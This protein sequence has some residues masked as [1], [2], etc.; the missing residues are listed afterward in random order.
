VAPEQTSPP[1]PKAEP[2]PTPVPGLAAHAAK[3]PPGTTSGSGV[4]RPGG[5]AQDPLNLFG[6]TVGGRFAVVRYLGRTSVAYIYRVVHMLMER[7]CF[8][9]VCD[10][11]P[12]APEGIPPALRREA[13]VTATS[14]NAALLRLLDAGVTGNFA[15][16]TQEWSDGPNLRSIIDQTA[17]LS[18]PDLLAI[19]MQLVDALCDLHR[20]GVVLRA[21]DPERILVPPRAG[22]PWLRLFDLSRIAWVGEKAPGES[23]EKSKRAT[24]F[25]IRSTRYMA[26][27]EIREVPADPRS[28]IYSLGV[29]LYEMLTGEYPY[30]TRGQGPGAYVVS[31][32]RDA[33]RPLDAGPRELPRDLPEIIGRMLA[34]SPEDR[35]ET[36]EAARRALEDVVVPDLVRLN[37]PGDRH[38]LE[39]WRRRVKVGLGR[40]LEREA[41]DDAGLADEATAI[42]P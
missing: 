35:F 13:Q 28:D 34:K 8:L 38:V 19:G 29:L 25:A 42:R 1:E 30:A 9:K 32:L 4:F 39:A 6:S 26:P 20:H 37:T 40:T 36:A 14:R 18:V 3:A 7:P 21:F 27:D 2:R 22:K 10:A 31:H 16:M 41:T 5:S 33:P 15:Y 17:T 24:G 23:L 12:T 11:E